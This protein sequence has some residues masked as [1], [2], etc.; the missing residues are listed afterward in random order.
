MSLLDKKLAALESIREKKAV[1]LYQALKVSTYEDML[2]FFPFRYED[3]TRFYTVKEIG[4]GM[5][6]V[7]VKGKLGGVEVMQQ[8]RKKVLVSTLRD[9]TGSVGLVWFNG[10]EWLRKTLLPNQPYILWGKPSRYQKK[11][12]IAHP[13]LQPSWTVGG[14]VKAGHLQPVYSTTQLLTKGGLHSSGIA[15]I[16]QRLL[17]IVGGGIE[18]TLPQEVMT[19]Y[20][21]VDRRSAFEGIHFPKDHACLKQAQYRFKFEEVFY[22][23]LR[24]RERHSLLVAKKKGMVFDDVTLL[25]RCYAMLPF[26]LT[27]AQK[28]A[29][30]AMYVDMKQ[31]RMNRLL[32]GDVGCGKTIVAFMGMLLPIAH[33]AQVAL[34]APTEILAQQH[35]EAIQ[36][37]ATRL[38]IIVGL[39]TGS[40]P[41]TE[42]KKLQ[43]GLLAGKVDVLVGTHALLEEGVQFKQLGLIVI[44]EQHRF[45]VVQRAKLQQKKGSLPPHIV[46]MT[47]TPIPRTLAMTLYSH[48]EVTM[49]DEMPPDRL[50]VKT[51]HAYDKD[52][53]RVLGF[54]RKQMAA[55]RQVYVVYPRIDYT[56]NDQYKDV[57]DGYESM[58]RAFPNVACGI[59]HGRMKPADKAYEMARFAKGATGIM[60][61][62]TVIE[63]GVNVPNATVMIIENAENFGLAQLHQLRGRIVRGKHQ[64][65]CILM[66]KKDLSSSTQKRINTMVATSD[67]FEIANIDLELR[68]PG[69][70]AGVA[71]SGMES[72]LVD[73][74]KDHQLIRE[75][76][77]AVKKLLSKDPELRS[78]EN[79]PVQKHLVRLNEHGKNMLKIS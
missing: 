6:F 63:V 22:L 71:Q 4:D 43:H 10:V 15:R 33:G 39:L 64:P 59:L 61:C 47:A 31:G 9:A 42:R 41:Q 32:Q 45:G 27:G 75:A 77:H 67:G 11:M 50:P 3:R 28:R 73:F 2:R 48:L 49:I 24:I 70:M 23:Q 16:Q 14:T 78:S 30:K 53:L 76:T 1:L 68:G 38:G 26:T 35:Y 5:P 51:Y 21:L 12:V 36:H 34:M 40:T 69:N 62:S 7:Q 19:E 79:Q 52:R 25:N 54:M 46:V 56:G 55:G 29:I 17:A 18:E 44:D 66:T 13:S 20:G 37:Y 65:Y 60:V 58:R 74:V 57:M 72:G 8:G